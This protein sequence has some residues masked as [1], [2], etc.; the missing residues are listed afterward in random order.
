MAKHT[1]V[2]ARA[3]WPLWLGGHAARLKLTRQSLQRGGWRRRVGLQIVFHDP[4]KW[5]R[6]VYQAASR[7][8]RS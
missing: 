3:H 6:R 4:R 5:R 8:C 1:A 2:V 7:P